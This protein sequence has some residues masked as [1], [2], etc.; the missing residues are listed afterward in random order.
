TDTVCPNFYVLSHAN[1]CTFAPQCAY[2]YLK[3]SFWYLAAPQ[4]F[5]NSR[6]MLDEIKA[7]IRT[8]GLETY[9][10]NTGNLSDSL[11][12]EKYRPL[13][14]QLVK[15]F[16]SEAEAKGR[17]HTL[18]LVTKGGCRECEGLF[19]DE[20]CGSVIVSF[21]VNSRRAAR[22]H[23]SGAAPVED[24]LAAAHKLKSLGWRVR[25]RIDPM[26]NG[27][28]YAWVAGQIAH[29]APER[30]TLG[31]LRADHALPRFADGS[32]FSELQPPAKIKGL[33]RYSKNIRLALYR[34]AI[35][36]LKGVAP[37]GLCEETPDIWKAL[38]LDTEAKPC[39]CCV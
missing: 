19:E 10:L 21:S 3:S 28:D 24:R 39:N 37:V 14:G 9:M 32:L 6:R 29:L 12:F 13:V 35:D 8:D 4:V 1:G 26:I 2:C 30:V 31:A 16:R 34:S 17:P 38:G 33:A 23:E 15:L 5:T 27:F 7:W 11:T 20:P 25:M 22:M 18:L 36:K